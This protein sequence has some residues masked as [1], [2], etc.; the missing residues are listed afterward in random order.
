MLLFLVVLCAGAWMATDGHGLRQAE[1]P[2][3]RERDDR[4]SGV[5][6]VGG[7]ASVP[8]AQGAVRAERE[9]PRRP[10]HRQIHP[11]PLPP[12]PARP[13][14]A[15]Q[16]VPI[17]CMCT[18]ASLHSI[19]HAIIYLCRCKYQSIGSAA[20]PAMSIEHLSQWVVDDHVR[21]ID[22]ASGDSVSLRAAPCN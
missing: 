10:L 20:A 4:G 22:H 16:L 14:L 17:Y 5:H 3:R 15:R 11:Q 8:A 18:S 19:Y 9:A 7:D 6:G 2:L 12:K 13:V 21:S 1:H